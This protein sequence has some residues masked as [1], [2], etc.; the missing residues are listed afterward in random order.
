MLSARRETALAPNA[1]EFSGR[2]PIPGSRPPVRRPQPA[3]RRCAPQARSGLLWPL[4]SAGGARP[5]GPGP[6]RCPRGGD[7]RPGAVPGRAPGAPDRAPQARPARPG[8][9]AVGRAVPREQRRAAEHPQPQAGPRPAVPRAAVPGGAAERLRWGPSPGCGAAEGAGPAGGPERRDGRADGAVREPRVHREAHRPRRGP[10]DQRKGTYSTASRCS[11]PRPRPRTR[12]GAAAVPRGEA[13]AGWRPRGPCRTSARRA[14]KPSRPLVL[15][16]DIVIPT[17]VPT[18]DPGALLQARK[19]DAADQGSAPEADTGQS[20]T[21]PPLRA[22]RRWR[23]HR[24][25]RTPDWT[26]TCGILPAACRP[27]EPGTWCRRS[28]RAPETPTTSSAASGTR[29]AKGADSVIMLRFYEASVHD[30]IR[31]LL[32]DPQFSAIVI[33]LGIS[34]RFVLDSERSGPYPCASSS[35]GAVAGRDLCFGS[36][37]AW[38]RH[39]RQRHHDLHIMVLTLEDPFIAADDHLS[40]GH[41]SMRPHRAGTGR[42][43]T[44]SRRRDAQGRC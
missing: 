2:A 36:G 14:E 24:P 7:R 21:P 35:A 31:I 16:S 3:R 38:S 11:G 44:L 33:I 9:R 15:A 28:R 8:P 30:E 27:W 6:Q 19:A 5:S 40:R 17:A 18:V 43:S 23:P 12:R 41:F 22:R 4:R 32:H 20:A 42:R 13:R 26:S 25:R 34:V 37:G 39:G 29:P 1:G 10:R